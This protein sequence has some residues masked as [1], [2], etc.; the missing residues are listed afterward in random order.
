MIH[1]I[2]ELGRLNLFWTP[3]E[4]ITLILNVLESDKSKEKC[5][6]FSM[7][8]CWFKRICTVFEWVKFTLISIFCWEKCIQICTVL[9]E[10]GRLV[11]NYEVLVDICTLFTVKLKLY[12]FYSEAHGISV[13]HLCLQHPNNNKDI[14]GLGK[15]FP[16]NPI[17]KL[18]AY[19]RQVGYKEEWGS[20]D[21]VSFL[22]PSY[23]P[24]GLSL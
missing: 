3:M 12:T 6:Q 1:N 14:W 7:I 2:L 24:A 11:C 8:F 13:C 15:K 10:E 21:T 18:R 5:V 22:L 19:L 4:K 23:A 20:R 16:N 17:K 9:E